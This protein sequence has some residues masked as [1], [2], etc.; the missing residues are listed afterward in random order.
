MGEQVEREGMIHEIGHLSAIVLET[1]VRTSI[2][3]FLEQ[4]ASWMCACC[5]RLRGLRFS[6]PSPLYPYNTLL[7]SFTT[8]LFLLLLS[9]TALLVAFPQEGR[10]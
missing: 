8:P 10:F 3:V 2:C 6:S 7:R 5:G 1:I 9:S 4:S